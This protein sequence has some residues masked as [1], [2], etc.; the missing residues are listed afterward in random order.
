MD[1][2]TEYNKV[3]ILEELV[4]AVNEYILIYYCSVVLDTFMCTFYT[5]SNIIW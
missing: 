2:Q 4:D 3:C 1:G 5:N